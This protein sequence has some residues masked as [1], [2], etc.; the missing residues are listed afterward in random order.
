MVAYIY[1]VETDYFA[2]SDKQGIIKI[3]APA[4]KY[5]LQIY[6]PQMSENYPASR[7]VLDG[8]SAQQTIVLNNLSPP[9]TAESTD[10]FSDLF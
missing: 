2:I 10:E 4:G 9:K 8:M 5:Q 6:H 7:I 1:V 3:D